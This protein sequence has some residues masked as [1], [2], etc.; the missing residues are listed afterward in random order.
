MGKSSDAG[1]EPG[2]HGSSGHLAVV[3]A[4]AL[5]NTHTTGQILVG[6]AALALAL[7]HDALL[8]KR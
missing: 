6:L 7:A 8:R 2:G 5:P 3:I 4:T 1:S